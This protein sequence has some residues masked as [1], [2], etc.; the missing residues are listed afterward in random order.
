MSRRPRGP[1][2][3][4][5][6]SRGHVALRRFHLRVVAAVTVVAVATVGISSGAIWL[7]E[8]EAPRSNIRDVWTAV[9]WAMETITTVGY[10][11]HHPTTATGKVIAAGL[12]VVGVALVGVITATV[13]TWFFSE[14]DV[15]REVRDIEQAE[16]KTEATL[17]VVLEELAALHERLERMDL[18]RAA[19]PQPPHALDGI[20]SEVPR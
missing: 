6:P 17:E 2:I 19:V 7:A 14:L 5:T 15:M 13:V 3:S 18:A 16:E 1:G 12:M 4:R 20:G 11:D 9:W 10:G 8:R